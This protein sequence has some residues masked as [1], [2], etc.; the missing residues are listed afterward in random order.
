MKPLGD[1]LE[2]DQ[3]LLIDN[4]NLESNQTGALLQEELHS[5][6]EQVVHRLLVAMSE[7]F[8]LAQFRH[9]GIESSPARRAF[10]SRLQ[11]Y[12]DISNSLQLAGCKPVR[13][14]WE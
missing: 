5:H 6:M 8:E 4:G 13:G 1:S 3:K 9:E 2:I 14:H 7:T 10:D 12:C 11:H